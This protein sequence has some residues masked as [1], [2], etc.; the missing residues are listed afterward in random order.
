MVYKSS[1]ELLMINTVLGTLVEAPTS[2]C[3]EH[4]LC[5]VGRFPSDWDPEEHPWRTPSRS[6]R[7]P[8]RS[9][10]KVRGDDASLEEKNTRKRGFV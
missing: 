3:F 10:F 7:S 5:D 2:V 4:V 6:K 9:K 1:E 8:R